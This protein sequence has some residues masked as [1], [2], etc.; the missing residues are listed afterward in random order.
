MELLEDFRLSLSVD[1]VLRGEGADPDIMRTK[2]PSILKAASSALREGIINLHPVAL[3]ETNRIVE[4]RHERI[5][6][7]GGNELYS[8]LVARHLAG[9]DQVVAVICTIG[10]QL[11]NLASSWMEENPLLGLALDGL[12]NSAVEAVGQQVCM[13]IGEQAQIIHMT[14]STPLSP[15]ETEWPVEVGQPQILTL[16]DPARAGIALTSGGMMIPK[17][18]ISFVVGIGPEMTQTDPCDLCSLRERCRYRHA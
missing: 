5:V 3:I 1:D 4:H 18:S 13:R 12:G 8:P 7:Q 14:A 9:A 10:P 17:K 15:G 11:E 2:K 16:L 6:L